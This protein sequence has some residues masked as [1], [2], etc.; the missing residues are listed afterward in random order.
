V[1]LSSIPD[2]A[3]V[4]ALRS[5]CL[6]TAICEA[7]MSAAHGTG[8]YQAWGGDL[9]VYDGTDGN[10]AAIAFRGESVVGSFCEIETFRSLR[11]Q[12]ALNV[13]AML[14]GLPPS[15][16]DLAAISTAYWHTDIDGVDTPFVTAVVWDRSGYL[17]GA[18]PWLSLW[19]HGVSVVSLQLIEDL[20]EAVAAC[21]VYF[22]LDAQEVALARSLHARRLANTS[23]PIF[24][25]P[26]EEDHMRRIAGEKDDYER[27]RQALSGIGF[28]MASWGEK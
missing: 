18:E 4:E 24:L 22:G 14:E 26:R 15:H 12:S 19:E 1:N 7:I 17:V 5:G 16:S 8:P 9:Y 27:A 23:G 6:L 11:S 25:T 10:Y 2:H 21:Q 28:Q 20:D 3:S 13:T